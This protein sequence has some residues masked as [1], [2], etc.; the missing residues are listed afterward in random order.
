MEYVVGIGEM[1][2][3]N[4]LDDVI[5]T[6]AL[7]SCVAVTAYSPLWKAAGMIHIALPIS[8]DQEDLRR[9]PAYYAHS[10]LPLFFQRFKEAYHCSIHDLQVGLFGGADS[11]RSSDAFTIGKKNILEVKRILKTMQID[12]S[13]EDVGGTESRTL[14]MKVLNGDIVQITQPI[15][16]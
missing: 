10:G 13:K 11:I 16:I 14:F 1:G 15:I 9:K 6:F 8:Y 3:S 4:K 12:V 5:K 7:A 2:F